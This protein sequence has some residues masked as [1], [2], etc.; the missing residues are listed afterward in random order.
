MARSTCSD[1]RWQ[2]HS[3]IVH[4]QVVGPYSWNTTPSHL[5]LLY[6]FAESWKLAVAW[7]RMQK[8]RAAASIFMCMAIIL[9]VS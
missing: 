4:I 1:S 7:P 9:A 2:P 5:V 3:N 8:R 6:M